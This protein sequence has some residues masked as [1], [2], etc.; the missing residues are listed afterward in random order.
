MKDI[1]VMK[2]CKVMFE[3]K[4][5]KQLRMG[6][7]TITVKSLKFEVANIVDCLCISHSRF[8]IPDELSKKVYIL[9]AYKETH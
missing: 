9:C 1:T 5:N 2:L 7:L 8:F 6:P 3:T 4:T